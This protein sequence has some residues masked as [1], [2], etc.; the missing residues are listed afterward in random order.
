MSDVFVAL[1]EE[2][3]F[4]VVRYDSVRITTTNFVEIWSVTQCEISEGHR[5]ALKRKRNLW[6]NEKLHIGIK[7]INIPTLTWYSYSFSV[8]GSPV[9]KILQGFHSALAFPFVQQVTGNQRASAT[10]ACL[11]VNGNDVSFLCTQVM[12]CV[13]ENWSII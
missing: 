5:N 8:L 12:A 7:K 13:G 2:A 11:T 6:L 9:S 3:F 10:F 1:F 4:F